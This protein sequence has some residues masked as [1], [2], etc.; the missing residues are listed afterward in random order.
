MTTISRAVLV[1]SIAFVN[2]EVSTAKEILEVYN[3]FASAPVKRFAD[4]KTAVRRTLALLETLLV[5]Y[6]EEVEAEE[7]KSLSASIAKS[8]ADPVIAEK[9][10]TRNG[11]IAYVGDE[12]IEF[13]SLRVAFAALRLPDSKHIAFR[14][15]LKAEKEA[16]FTFGKTSIKFALV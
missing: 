16:T 10:L 14:Q 1:S 15:I 6:P 3:R 4:R 2:N 11:V 8:W 5:D 7:K 13:K 9:R 12:A